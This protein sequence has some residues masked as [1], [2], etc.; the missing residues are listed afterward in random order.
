MSL[1]WVIKCLEL[2]VRSYLHILLLFLRFLSFFCIQK[3]LSYTN[4]FKRMDLSY[5]NIVNFTQ[6]LNPKRIENTKIEKVF[7]TTQL[8]R[9][10]SSLPDP[11]LFY[12]HYTKTDWE[13]IF[14]IK[15]GNMYWIHK[16]SDSEVRFRIFWLLEHACL[17]V[18]RASKDSSYLRKTQ[19]HRHR[20]A[21]TH[22]HTYIYIYI[23]IYIY[24]MHWS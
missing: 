16:W 23:Y 24:G 4:I 1:S 5:M 14:C 12:N 9:T 3:D 11:V 8:S 20:H 10:G 6:G 13:I 2:I 21:H 18:N 15:Y 7:H 17:W 22:T 19:T